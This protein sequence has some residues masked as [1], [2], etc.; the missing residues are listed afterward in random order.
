MKVAKG[1]LD[2]Q[3]AFVQGRLKLDGDMAKAMSL[4]DILKNM[5]KMEF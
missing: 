1:E 4:G 2:L 5:P 3:T